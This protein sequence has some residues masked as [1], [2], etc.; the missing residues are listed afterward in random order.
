M[1]SAGAHEATITSCFYLLVKFA[2]MPPKQFVCK[3]DFGIREM[4][5]GDF[6]SWSRVDDRLEFPDLWDFC[7]TT[8]N[9]H[10]TAALESFAH[11]LIT[12]PIRDSGNTSL[13]GNSNQP[14]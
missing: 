11:I 1:L 6:R 8:G 2:E 3:G 5:M 13:S 7:G 4:K 14:A 12:D 9:T 10:T